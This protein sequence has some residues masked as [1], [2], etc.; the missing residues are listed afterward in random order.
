MLS[1]LFTGIRHE[2]SVCRHVFLG[3]IISFVASVCTLSEKMAPGLS[4]SKLTDP[5]ENMLTSADGLSIS[6]LSISAPETIHECNI[7]PHI[8]HLTGQMLVSI[9]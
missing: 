7:H 8:T 5:K 3:A 9:T 1:L 2:G 6:E 4:C